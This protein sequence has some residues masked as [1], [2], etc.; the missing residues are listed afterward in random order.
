MQR[1]LFR[2][3][4]FWMLSLV[5]AF[6]LANAL[7]L[8][9]TNVQ[10]VHA[11]FKHEA[12]YGLCLDDTRAIAVGES[13]LI[14]LSADSGDTWV[15]SDRFTEVAL[16]DVECGGGIELYVGQGGK[17]YRR[18]DDSIEVVSTDSDARL[19]SVAHSQ[20]SGLTVAVGA[21]GTIL[22]STDGGGS[23]T[24]PVVDWFAVLDDYVDP[25]LYDVHVSDQGVVTV[26]GEFSL[27]LQSIDQ[28][29]TWATRRRG[30]SSL[31]G[32]NIDQSGVGY[33]VGQEGT[34][35]ET[36]DGGTSWTPLKTPTN[37]ILLN[38]ASI[39]KGVIVASGMRQL[40]FSVDGGDHW[41][42]NK[43][44]AFLE[45]WYQ[46]LEVSRNSVIGQPRVLLAGHRANI[47]KLELQ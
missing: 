34:L 17:V 46:G 19:M 23:W 24:S 22:L 7:G 20:P 28:G 38:V 26:V 40:I 18:V 32:L 30:D 15:E 36:V 35:L 3:S 21:F 1:R 41:K 4:F 47:L 5:G 39:D 11:G 12:I 37:D 9:I 16:L 8:E 6:A 13:G 42:I 31:F 2:F 45:G 43:N 29:E 27:I 14:L 10:S 44:P 25:H 33:A